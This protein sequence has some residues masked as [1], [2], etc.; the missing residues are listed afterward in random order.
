MLFRVLA[1]LAIFGFLLIPFNIFVFTDGYA[2][3]KIFKANTI[4]VCGY[5]VVTIIV[6]FVIVFTC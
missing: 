6:M 1:A 2:N 4:L 5:A 3:D